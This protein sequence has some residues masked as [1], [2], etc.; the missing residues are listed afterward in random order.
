MHQSWG[1]SVSAASRPATRVRW[2]FL[3]AT[4]VAVAGHAADRWVEVRTPHFLVRS[5]AGEAKAA[6]LSAELE[7]FRQVTRRIVTTD[8]NTAGRDLLRVDAYATWRG[9]RR[10]GAPSGTLGFYAATET[11]PVAV[12]SLEEG[13]A[14]QPTGIQVLRHEYTHHL[15]HRHGSL[16][17][18][19]WYDEGFADYLSTIEFRGDTVAVGLPEP[20]SL[21][22]LRH[23]DNWIP[24]RDLMESRG[25]YLTNTGARLPRDPNRHRHDIAYH[26]AQGWLITHFLQHSPEFRAKLSPYILALNQPNVDAAAAFQQAFGITYREFERRIRHYWTE[27]ALP[28]GTIE[29]TELGALPA[30]DVRVLDPLEAAAVSDEMLARLAMGRRRTVRALNRVLQA[31]IRVDEMRAMLGN[32]ALQSKDIESAQAHAD[33]LLAANPESAPGATLQGRVLLQS[34]PKD[35]PAPRQVAEV[36]SW[37]DRARQAD[38]DYVPALLDTARLAVLPGQPVR[39]EDVDALQAVL[40]LYPELPEAAELQIALL[41]RA[42]RRDDARARAQLLLEWSEDMAQR[43][44]LERLAE[45][46]GLELQH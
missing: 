11:G 3:A 10:A 41:A 31:G 15:L 38:P 35:D 9:Y 26:Y 43:R 32:L 12:L 8:L 45:E 30:A 46:F 28:Y 4:V 25:R 22:L 44:R 37:F 1:D 39:P 36:R 24:V 19:R 42:G 14:W 34:L 5:D 27:G 18:P 20:M 40:A 33:A 13:E 16:L 2:L 21:P 17:Y 29:L 7:R 6:A 23:I